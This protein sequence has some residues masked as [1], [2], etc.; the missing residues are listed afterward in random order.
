MVSKPRLTEFEKGTIMALFN[1]GRSQR[2]IALSLNR[3]RCAVQSFIKNRNRLKQAEKRGTASKLSSTQRRALVREACKGD[4]YASELKNVLNLPVTV[5]CVQKLLKES[6]LLAYKTMITAPYLLERDR[7]GRLEF[8]R[9][10]VAW[11][12]RK[13]KRTIFSDEKN[14]T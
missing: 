11:E 8:S 3:S 1:E 6:L 4:M 12:P 9:D 7:L 2:E 14:L 10:Y 5:R 13:W